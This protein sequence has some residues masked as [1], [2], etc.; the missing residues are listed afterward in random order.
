M[1]IFRQKR[2]ITLDTSVLIA[3]IIT[4]HEDSIVKKVVTKSITDDRLMLTDIIYE[5]CL[6]YADKRKS[7]ASN[8]EITAKLSALSP[9]IIK[10]SPIPSDEELLKR[11][12]IRDTND[13]KILYSVEMTDSV[14]LITYDDDFSDIEG[15]K[16]KI[17]DPVEYLYEDEIRE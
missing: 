17:M 11:Y 6:K 7:K 8:E 4:K 15:V 5:E 13:L 10:I 14:I 1:K 16:A 2:N 3:W 9:K 12:R